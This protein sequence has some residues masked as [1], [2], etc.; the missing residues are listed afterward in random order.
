MEPPRRFDACFEIAESW[1]RLSDKNSRIEPHDILL[2]NHELKEIALMAQG[3][4]QSDAHDMTEKM[5]NYT[6]AAMKYYGELR[7]KEKISGAITNRLGS[8]TH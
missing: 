4:S 1:R 8:N 2:I 6:E 5:Y 3:L 7:K